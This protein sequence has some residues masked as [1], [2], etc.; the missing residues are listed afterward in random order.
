LRC[1]MGSQCAPSGS[2]TA[3]GTGGS[4]CLRN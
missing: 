3:V 1:T 2:C 4:F